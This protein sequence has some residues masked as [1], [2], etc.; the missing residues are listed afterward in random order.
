MGQRLKKYKL[1]ELST[2]GIMKEYT[3]K[4]IKDIIKEL[5]SIKALERKRRNIFYA[6]VK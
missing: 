2:F 6:K 5:L 3:S 4:Y 1:Y